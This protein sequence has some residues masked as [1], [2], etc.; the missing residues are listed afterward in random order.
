MLNSSY[1]LRNSSYFRTTN[2]DSIKTDELFGAIHLI[3]DDSTQTPFLIKLSRL[4]GCE[5]A[6]TAQNLPPY[7]SSLINFSEENNA[8]HNPLDLETKKCL[9]KLYSIRNSDAEALGFVFEIIESAFSKHELS[10]VNALLF[11]F[12]P[13]QTKPIV[14]TGLLRATSRA[15]LKLSSWKTCAAHVNEYLSSHGE[16]T[17]HI[18]RGII[19]TDD[20]IILSTT[21]IS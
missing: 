11:N 2:Y 17:K 13:S 3:V 10:F 7:N 9:N 19:R 20:P 8:F 18:L 16:N 14:S 12:D 4:D 21:T 5:N 1:Q 6:S 15:K